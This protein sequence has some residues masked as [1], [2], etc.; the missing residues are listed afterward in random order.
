MTEHGRLNASSSMH[1]CRRT[2]TYARSNY[3]VYAYLFIPAVYVPL[4]EVL[5]GESRA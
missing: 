5:L 4:G 3:R 2:T 1:I